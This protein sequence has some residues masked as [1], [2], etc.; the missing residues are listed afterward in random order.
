M[1]NLEVGLLILLVVG[2]IASNL[3]VLKYSAKFKM[4]QFG[5]DHHKKTTKEKNVA[6]KDDQD[7]QADSDKK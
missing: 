3:A 7:Q 4:S 5:K 1:S 6:D 2:I